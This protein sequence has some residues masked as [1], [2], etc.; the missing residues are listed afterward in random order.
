MTY[1]VLRPRFAVRVRTHDRLHGPHEVLVLPEV[2]CE[3]AEEL[4]G[5]DGVREELCEVG[6]PEAEVTLVVTL[7]LKVLD[8]VEEVTHVAA[9]A[10]RD[11]SQ[12]RLT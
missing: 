6:D 1:R 4:G 3:L 8:A 5:L 12:I 7:D 2:S 11:K 10:G 9:D